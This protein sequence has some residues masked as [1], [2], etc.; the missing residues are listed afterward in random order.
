MATTSWISVA[1]D[2]HFPIQVRFF[3]FYLKLY[4]AKGNPPPYAHA[5]PRGLIAIRNPCA[6]PPSLHPLTHTPFSSSTPRPVLVH[7]LL[8]LKHGGI[9]NRISPSVYSRELA[10]MLTTSAPALETKPSTSTSWHRTALWKAW[11]SL[12]LCSSPMNSTVSWS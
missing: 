10:P 1:A 8:N 12:R 11:A 2:S 9:Y 6:V 4:V 5:H 7:L 3:A